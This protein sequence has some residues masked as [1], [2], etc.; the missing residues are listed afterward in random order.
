MISF[1]SF[2]CL[3]AVPDEPLNLT[4]RNVTSRNLTLE[5]IRP[6]HNNAPILG[7]YIF[8]THIDFL[9]GDI[10]TLLVKGAIEQQFIDELL[11]NVMYTFAVIAFNE[12]GNSSVSVHINVTTFGEGTVIYIINLC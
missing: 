4:A 12:E 10:V 6:H 11:P 1:T 5:W 7:Y 3:L 9:G 2:S 8:Y